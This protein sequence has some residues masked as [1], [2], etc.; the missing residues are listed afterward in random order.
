[1]RLSLPPVKGIDAKHRRGFIGQLIVPERDVEGEWT[2]FVLPSATGHRLTTADGEVL[3][4]FAKAPKDGQVPVDG[5][6]LIGPVPDR[7]SECIDL[8]ASKWLVHPAV[9]GP[10]TGQREPERLG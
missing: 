10:E 2:R 9:G 8:R 4:A 7:S 1:M 3:Y 6:V 5:A